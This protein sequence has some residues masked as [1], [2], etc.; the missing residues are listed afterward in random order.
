MRAHDVRHLRGCRKCGRLGDR[1]RMI[2]DPFGADAGTYHP[3]CV[4]EVIGFDGVLK[5]PPADRGQFSLWDL[6]VA[7][8]KQLLA[9]LDEP[10]LVTEGL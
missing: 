7:Q 8:M 2:V 3:A 10:S 6:G 4:L 9:S 5:L 1:R